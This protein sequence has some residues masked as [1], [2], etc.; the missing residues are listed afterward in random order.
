MELESTGKQSKVE[1]GPM[2]VALLDEIA[3]RLLA[4]ENLAKAE[5]P[6]GIVEPIEKFTITER[7]TPLK[8][9]KSWFS[10]SIINDGPND[11]FVIVNT[12]KSFDP[13]R[14]ANGETYN[15]DMK[16]AVIEDLLFWCNH[17]ETARVRIVGVR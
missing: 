5:K 1:A 17:G 12:Q 6:E 8:L 4:L 14:M 2:Q 11:T 13:H 15:V 3:E 10:V 16:H 9:R 7:R